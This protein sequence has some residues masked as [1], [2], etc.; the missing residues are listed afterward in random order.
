VAPALAALL[1]GTAGRRQCA[2]GLAL[3]ADEPDTGPVAE[4]LR[5]CEAAEAPQRIAGHDRTTAAIAGP[6]ATSPRAAS[7]RTIASRPSPAAARTTAGLAVRHAVRTTA[8][9]FN[10][11]AGSPE[12]R[13]SAG[14]SVAARIRRPRSRGFTTAGSAHRLRAAYRR[15]PLPPS[16]G[17]QRRMAVAVLAATTLWAGAIGT[18]IAVTH[19]GP[20][21]LQAV[22]HGLRHLDWD[23]ADEGPRT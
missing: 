23:E 7:Q 6:R 8:A 14:R 15:T 3:F 5:I 12:P 19:Q 20:A 22:H 10:A 17:R 4:V 11:G 2:A 18:G 1:E 21:V 16:P 9:A 13:R